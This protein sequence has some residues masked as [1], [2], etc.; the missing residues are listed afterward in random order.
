MSESFCNDIV[1]QFHI[2]HWLFQVASVLLLL[3]YL[4]WGFLWLRLNLILAAIAFIC[5]SFFV[6]SSLDGIIWNIIFI[7]V[8]SVLSIPLFLEFRPVR[9]PPIQNRVYIDHFRQFFTKRQF[10]WTMKYCDLHVVKEPGFICKE[11]TPLNGYMFF[12]QVPAGAEIQITKKEWIIGNVINGN[13]VGVID[14]WVKLDNNESL[15]DMKWNVS[16]EVTKIDSN[17]PIRYFSFSP[18]GLNKHVFQKKQGYYFRQ[19]FY[20]AWLEDSCT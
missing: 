9:L 19:C 14:A 8:H 2:Q 16:C 18:Q 4:Q 15:E 10:K 13:W 1:G 5:W 11:G 6:L 17:N 3:S 12:F 7:A 20:A